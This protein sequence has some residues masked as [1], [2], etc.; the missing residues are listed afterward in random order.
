VLLHSPLGRSSGCLKSC[1]VVASAIMFSLKTSEW[2]NA[3]E[4][5]II[6]FVVG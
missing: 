6:V 4:V 3:W 1:W 5:V 2:S